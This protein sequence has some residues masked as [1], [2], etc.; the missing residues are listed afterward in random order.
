M[1]DAAVVSGL[2][3]GY[4][5]LF[6]DDDN[7]KCRVSA[8]DLQACGKSHNTTAHNEYIVLH[9]YNFPRS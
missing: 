1:D 7:L 2:V 8:K 3:P 5:I 4:R 6:F 9:G